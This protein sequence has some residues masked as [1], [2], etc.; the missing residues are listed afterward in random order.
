MIFEKKE[1]TAQMEKALYQAH[2]VSYSEYENS[3]DIQIKVE[4]AREKEYKQSLQIAASHYHR[5][6]G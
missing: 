1:P 3:H 5:I 6:G 4:K 2:G